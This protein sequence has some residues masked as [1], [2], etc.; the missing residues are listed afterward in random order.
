MMRNA[1]NAL[2]KIVYPLIA[3]LLV[4]SCAKDK[5]HTLPEGSGSSPTTSGAPAPAVDPGTC[6]GLSAGGL[7]VWLDAGN[8]TAANGAGVASW[9]DCANAAFNPIQ[10]TAAKQPVFHSSGG[11]GNKAYVDFD[12]LQQYLASGTGG[13]GFSSGLTIFMLL[14]V[15]DYTGDFLMHPLVVN[16]AAGTGFSVDLFKDSL[17]PMVGNHG[18]TNLGSGT[19]VHDTWYLVTFV[20]NAAN[21]AIAEYQNGEAVGIHPLSAPYT[22]NG[23]NF[24]LFANEAHTQFTRGKLAELMVFNA[25][26]SDSDVASLSCYFSK[27]YSLGIGYCN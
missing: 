16:D 11:P 14:S 20:Q 9:H 13:I 27:K 5:Q 6:S 19:Y 12:G 22:G 15:A 7:Q 1:R 24:A 18:G 3:G 26:F 2:Q 23:T 4:V 10:A 17:S 25:L 8:I 21:T